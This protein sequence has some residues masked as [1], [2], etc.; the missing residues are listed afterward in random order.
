MSP[1]FVTSKSC[2]GTNHLDSTLVPQE[3]PIENVTFM[4]DNNIEH[5]QI[6]IP[7]H[8]SESVTIPL[9]SIANALEILH[10]TEKHPVLIHCNKG[11]VFGA[12]DTSIP[13]TLD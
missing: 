3:Y 5:F 6:P 8:K 12:T 2:I 13:W 9:Q 10:N 7:A 1:A 11:K 4:K